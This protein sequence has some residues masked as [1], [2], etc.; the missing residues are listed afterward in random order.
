MYRGP[1]RSSAK[2]WREAP[3]CGGVHVVMPGD[4]CE[5]LII[6]P[7]RCHYYSNLV[8]ANRPSM[9]LIGRQV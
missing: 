1:H 9:T 7:A 6:D 3:R 8:W 5:D 4:R 2:A